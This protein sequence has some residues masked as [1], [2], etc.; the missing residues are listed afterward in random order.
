MDMLIGTCAVIN[1]ASTRFEIGYR[2]SEEYWGSGYGLEILEGL[3]TYCL[4]ELKAKEITAEVYK[5]NVPSIRLLEKSSLEFVREY[6]EGDKKVL[7]Y[8]LIKKQ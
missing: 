7:L 5:E 2:F 4:T 3:V 6:V 8:A 1:K